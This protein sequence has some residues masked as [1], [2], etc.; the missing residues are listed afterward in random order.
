LAAGAVLSTKTHV[1]TG[2]IS[3]EQ[4]IRHVID[5]GAKPLH[6]DWEVRLDESESPFMAHRSWG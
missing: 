1:P 3:L 4:V 6:D 2:R 5:L